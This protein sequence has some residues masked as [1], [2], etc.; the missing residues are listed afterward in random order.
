MKTDKK[1]KVLFK[2]T[3][4]SA[5][6]QIAEGLLNSLFSEKYKDFSAGTE[7]SEVNPYAV[8][9]MSEIGIDITGHKSKGLEEF[10][11]QDFDYVI[12]RKI[13]QAL[14]GMIFKV[15]YSYHRLD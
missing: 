13:S 9:V 7:P 5:R 2:C 12:T 15:Y 14:E 4:N 1:Q 10:I 11:K 6:S 8:K 3:H